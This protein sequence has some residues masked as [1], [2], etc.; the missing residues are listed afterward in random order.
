[1][2]ASVSKPF[3]G[4]AVSAMIDQNIISSLDDDICNVIPN[5]WKRSACRN[6]NHLDIPVTWRMLVT[7]RSS[8]R[9]DIPSVRDNTG[10]EVDPSNGPSGGYSGYAA[11][12]PTCPLDD[13]TGFY[14]DFLTD[15][16][17]ETLVGSDM[18]VRGGGK[19]NWYQVGESNGGAW[20][21]YAPGSRQRYSNFAVGYLAALVE[22]AT[23]QSFPDFCRSNLFAPLG[24]TRTEWFRNDLPS[25]TREAV[26]VESLRFNRFTDVG[27]YCFIDY[28]SGQLRTS[29]ADMAKFCDSMLSYGA[30]SLWSEGV[31]KQAFACQER[32]SSGNKP[33]KCEFGVNWIVLDNSMKGKMGNDD[34]I[35]TFERYDWTD[36]V[37]HDGAEAGSQT[38]I[39]ILPAAKV[40]AVV[41]TNTDYND[42]YA[43]QKLAG[44]IGTILSG[45]EQG[46]GGFLAWLWDLLFRWW[47]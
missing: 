2:L 42:D 46:G 7:H 33:S 9:D 45:E 13:V 16:E 29:A 43:A 19:I 38:Q 17:T 30:P 27:H 40:Y 1:M 11:G 5:A 15:K 21:W 18:E 34:W 35:D 23:G 20:K 28:A 36:G 31:G 26:P 25:D 8:L 10:D 12:N 22:L 3:A 47:R 37:M 14:R 24:M 4:A 39:L 32:D 44:E 6:P 41:L